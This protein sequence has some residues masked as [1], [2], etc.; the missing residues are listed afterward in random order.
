[1]SRNSNA[2]DGA[3]MLEAPQVMPA[4]KDVDLLVSDEKAVA[5]AP[6]S[7]D[8]ETPTAPPLRSALDE[9]VF[10]YPQMMTD[11]NVNLTFNF[12]MKEGLTRWKFQ[13]LTH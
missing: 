13:A 3:V 9:T 4:K 11:A 1:M 10:F 8:K 2:A 6:P 7:Q 5:A 12:K